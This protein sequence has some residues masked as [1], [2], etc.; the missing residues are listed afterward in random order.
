[1]CTWTP[2]GP[3]ENSSCL[4][5]KYEQLKGSKCF[6]SHFLLLKSQQTFLAYMISLSESLVKIERMFPEDHLYTQDL[7]REIENCFV[8]YRAPSGR[9]VCHF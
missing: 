1:M 9:A 7:A 4:L 5:D 2:A 3:L 6:T 8:I